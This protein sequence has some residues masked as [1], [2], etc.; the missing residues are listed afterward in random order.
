MNHKESFLR[1]IHEKKKIQLTFN[2]K[3]KGTITR[4]C[5][6]FDYGPTKAYSDNKDR[7]HF[8]D[9]NSPEGKHVLLLKPEQI[10]NIK[11]I[12]E[13]FEPGDYVHWKTRWHMNRDW[14]KY[15]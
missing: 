4:N 13:C 6:P 2:S 15:S 5:I 9:L 10:V 12:D 3:E 14:G 11:I 1:A 8:Y 7:Y